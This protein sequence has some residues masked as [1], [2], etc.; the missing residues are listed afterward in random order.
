MREKPHVTL[1]RIG[2]GLF[3][4][5]LGASAFCFYNHQDEVVGAFTFTDKF[6]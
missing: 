4:E 3:L 1:D 2:D 5:R 6:M